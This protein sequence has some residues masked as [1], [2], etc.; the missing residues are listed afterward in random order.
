MGDDRNNRRRINRSKKKL[1]P[2]QRQKAN[3]T[4]TTDIYWTN[5]PGYFRIESKNGFF[6]KK[7]ILKLQSFHISLISRKNYWSE[8]K[9]SAHSIVARS[10]LLHDAI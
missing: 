3:I 10:L 6:G 1:S 4:A 5:I 8:Q 7:I 2:E 9:S